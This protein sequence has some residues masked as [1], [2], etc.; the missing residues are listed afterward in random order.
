MLAFLLAGL[1]IAAASSAADPAAEARAALEREA[2]EAVNGPLPAA[3]HRRWHWLKW[4]EEGP[5][6][7]GRLH[8]YCTGAVEPKPRLSIGREWTWESLDPR[9]LSASDRD[10]LKEWRFQQFGASYACGTVFEIGDTG[11][12]A[13][14]RF[15]TCDARPVLAFTEYVSRRP[16]LRYRDDYLEVTVEALRNAG[17]R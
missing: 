8:D 14:R 5:A 13:L 7:V 15:E 2:L 3:Y 10:A 1:A 9:P 17:C 16:E 4:M 11:N 12:Q 6:S